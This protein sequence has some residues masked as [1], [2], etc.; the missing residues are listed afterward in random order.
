LRR[1]RPKAVDKLA[2]SSQ[3]PFRVVGENSSIA[4]Q[5]RRGF[6]RPGL[7]QFGRS[8]KS[9]WGDLA[10]LGAQLGSSV[11]EVL[12]AF[13]ASL[14]T[15]WR[16]RDDRAVRLERHCLHFEVGYRQPICG[17]RA[18]P[19]TPRVVGPSLTIEFAVWVLHR[20]VR[21]EQLHAD[22]IEHFLG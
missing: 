15:I 10:A 11:S 12:A 4:D 9:L 2:I 21:P 1:R 18:I 14:V 13:V 6:P 8:E 17:R 16:T 5:E 22:R 20:L 7:C 19:L 3:S